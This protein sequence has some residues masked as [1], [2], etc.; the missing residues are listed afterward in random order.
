MASIGQVVFPTLA[1]LRQ[2]SY[3]QSA[4][5][6]QV[7]GGPP[8]YD[9]PDRGVSFLT[10]AAIALAITLPSAKEQNLHPA[11]LDIAQRVPPITETSCDLLASRDFSGLTITRRNDVPVFGPN[12][13]LTLVDWIG[14][15]GVPTANGAGQFTVMGAGTLGLTIP[16]SYEQRLTEVPLLTAPEGPPGVYWY[17]RAD[18][19]WPAWGNKEGCYTWL[20]WERMD[21]PLTA[22]SACTLTL[23]ITY[24]TYVFSDNHLTDST[25]VTT[26]GFTATPHTATYTLAVVAGAQTLHVTLVA[27]NE[28]TYPLFERVGSMVLSGFANGAWVIGEPTLVQSDPAQAI[29]KT[30]EGVDPTETPY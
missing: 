9:D 11:D 24:Y 27:P 21:I 26:F 2:V 1:Q 8:T 15:G 19:Y 20:G 10:S 14:T 5:L 29:L 25:R 13:A 4:S 23:T 3:C 6:V 22:P 7:D 18:H 16:S 17:R 12:D 28:G 30:F